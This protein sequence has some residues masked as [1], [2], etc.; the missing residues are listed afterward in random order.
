MRRSVVHATLTSNKIKGK[1]QPI[2]KITP[3]HTLTHEQQT[4]NNEQQNGQKRTAKG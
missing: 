3:T 4:T 1:S 2:T